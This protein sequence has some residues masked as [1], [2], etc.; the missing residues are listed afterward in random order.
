MAALPTDLHLY[1]E[2]ADLVQHAQWCLW[3]DP[4]TQSEQVGERPRRRVE[5][6]AEYLFLV[7]CHGAVPVGRRAACSVACTRD[8][9]GLARQ[10]GQQWLGSR[11]RGLRR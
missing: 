9:R 8:G 3:A 11:Q 10:A 7:M 6:I 4:L 5:H 1:S 2:A